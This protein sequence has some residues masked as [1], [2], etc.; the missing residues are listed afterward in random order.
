MT[1]K[2]AAQEKF[3]A[4]AKEHNQPWDKE[5]IDHLKEIQDEL[6]DLWNYASLDT[7]DD[8]MESIMEYAEMMWQII[9]NKV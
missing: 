1:F 4:G 2:Q 3:N 7:E 6:L 9:E 8:V 5:H